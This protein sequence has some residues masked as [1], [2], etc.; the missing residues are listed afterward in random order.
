VHHI[1]RDHLLYRRTNLALVALGVVYVSIAVERERVMGREEIYPFAAWS[2]F[3]MVHNECRDYSVRVLEVNGTKLERPIYFEDAVGYF[4]SATH[5]GAR[6]CIQRLG[7]AIE[8][9]NALAAERERA[10]LEGM[11]LHARRSVGYDLVKRR[12]DPLVRFREGTFLEERT[13]A[14]F[15]GKAAGAT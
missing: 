1:K 3:S 14:T 9:K 12:Y 10:E 4:P 7:A 15:R 5:N 11:H 6:M 8:Q 2:L 13:L